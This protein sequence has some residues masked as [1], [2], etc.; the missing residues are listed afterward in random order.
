MQQDSSQ[1]FPP[2]IIILW[3]NGDEE[4]EVRIVDRIIIRF[5]GQR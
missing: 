4:V 2:I 5:G 3:L 1:A